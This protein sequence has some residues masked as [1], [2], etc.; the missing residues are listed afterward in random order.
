MKQVIPRER[1]KQDVDDAVAYYLKEGAAHA[2]L[3]FVDA[4]EDAYSLL[5]R[6]PGVGASRYAYELDVPGL[7][8]WPLRRHPYLI[9]YVELE[10]RVDVWRVLHNR[11]DLPS[12]MQQFDQ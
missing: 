4:V 10:N 6:H 2:A 3:S 9:F 1:A 12:W 7:R 11:R 5:G 8:T